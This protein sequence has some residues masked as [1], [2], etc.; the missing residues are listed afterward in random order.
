MDEPFGP[1]YVWPPQKD[2]PNCECCTIDLCDRGRDSVMACASLTPAEHQATVHGCPCSAATT[3]HTAAWRAAQ[4][5]VTCLA[6]DLPLRDEA[7]DLLR[8]LADDRDMDTDDGGLVPQLTVRGL[9]QLQNLRPVITPLGRMYL[10][11]RDGVR[12]RAVVEV[13]DV[14]RRARTARVVVA[15]WRPDEPVTVLLD[16]VTS[17]TDLDAD[18]LPG[19]L[20]E[21]E[22]NTQAPDVERLVLTGF[23]AGGEGR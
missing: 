11:A 13:I 17:D 20:L 4:V 3:P 19:R 14:D 8:A 7:E 16:Q 10:A 6:R 1:E 18:T 5:R 22:A 2:C 12:S 9:A 21:A 15:A 23:R